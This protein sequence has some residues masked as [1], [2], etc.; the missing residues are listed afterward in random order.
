MIGDEVTMNQEELALLFLGA[1]E[2]PNVLPVQRSDG[3]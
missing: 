3:V 1:V 2:A